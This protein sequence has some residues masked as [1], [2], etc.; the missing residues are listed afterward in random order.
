MEEYVENW[1]D[2]IWT[3]DTSSREGLLSLNID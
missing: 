2:M 1:D 3:V